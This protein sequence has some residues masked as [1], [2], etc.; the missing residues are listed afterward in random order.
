VGG[1]NIK[2]LRRIN[3]G[4]KRQIKRFRRVLIKGRG[5]V[6]NACLWVGGSF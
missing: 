6:F 2:V 1:G 4:P 3:R 5:L